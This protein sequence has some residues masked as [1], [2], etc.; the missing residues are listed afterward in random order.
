VNGTYHAEVEMKIAVTAMGANLEGRVDPRFGR[1][2]GFVIFDT[3]S[4]EAAHVDNTQNLN[5]IQTANLICQSF[6]QINSTVNI[7][8]R[9]F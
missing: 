7:G 4:G 9:C 3:E 5:A 6:N 1:A 8:R 2:K